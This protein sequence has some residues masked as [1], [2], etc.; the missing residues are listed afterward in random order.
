MT[1]MEKRF[2]IKDM[3]EVIE[4]EFKNKVWLK[5]RWHWSSENIARRIIEMPRLQEFLK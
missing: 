1:P 4:E 5:G 2:L 3:A